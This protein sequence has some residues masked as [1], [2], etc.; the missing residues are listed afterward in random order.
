MANYVSKS[1]GHNCGSELASSVCSNVEVEKLGSIPSIMLPRDVRYW[2][3]TARFRGLSRF[4][5]QEVY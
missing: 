5:L 4:L 1:S 3:E 2:L